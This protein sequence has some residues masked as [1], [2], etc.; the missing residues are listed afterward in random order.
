[1]RTSLQPQVNLSLLRCNSLTFQPLSCRV[2]PFY[3][4]SFSSMDRKTDH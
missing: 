1:M 4:V 2:A 3:S